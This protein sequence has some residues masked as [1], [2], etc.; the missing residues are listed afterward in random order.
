MP[1]FEPAASEDAESAPQIIEVMIGLARR[2]KRREQVKKIAQILAG[3]DVAEL[4]WRGEVVQVAIVES[5][6]DD[7]AALM[8]KAEDPGGTVWAFTSGE[9]EAFLGGVRL[10]EFS[11]SVIET[12]PDNS[13]IGK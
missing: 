8:R 5:E 3:V 10:D 2:R 9:W 11:R 7:Y 4:E 1:E 13:Y 6:V 12:Y